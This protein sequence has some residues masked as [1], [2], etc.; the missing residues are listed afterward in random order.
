MEHVT[1]ARQSRLQARLSAVTS[2]PTAASSPS[3]SALALCNATS[4]PI[5]RTTKDAGDGSSDDRQNKNLGEDK[6]T[7]STPR[8]TP[9][10]STAGATTSPDMSLQP[11]REALTIKG[12]DGRLRRKGNPAPV[13]ASTTQR[14]FLVLGL[15]LRIPHRQSRILRM[16]FFSL[17]AVWALWSLLLLLS[18]RQQALAI[19]TPGHN[20]A[21]HSHGHD[22]HGH[23]SHKFYTARP[24]KA[25][26]FASV[27]PSFAA[28][29]RVDTVAANGNY[30]EGAADLGFPSNAT[31]LPPLCAVTVA[32]H[33]GSSN[34]RLALFLPTATNWN[35][36]LMT[37]GS[38]SFAGGINW[39]NMGEA[40]HYGFAT[41]ATDGGHNSSQSDLD[42]APTTPA[43]LA[44]W[45]Y[46]AL[47]GTVAL[48]KTLVETYYSDARIAYSYYSGCSTGGR[49][50]LKEIQ[51]SPDSFDGA[52]VGA[53]AWDTSRLMPWLTRIGAANLPDDGAN[54]IDLPDFA[55]LAAAALK[56]CDHLDGHNDSII[57][58][59]EACVLDWAP[60]TCGNAAVPPGEP[61]LTP[62]QV[63]TARYLYADAFTAS[64]DFIH[65][66]YS[67]GSEDQWNVYLAFGDASDFDTRYERFW[68]YN[69]TTWN[70]TLYSDQVFYDSLRLNLGNASADDYDISAYRDRGGKVLMY[71]GLADGVITPRMTTYYYNQTMKAMNLTLATAL[72]KR[73]ET[74]ETS[75]RH[76]HHKDTNPPI[77]DFFR[78]IQVPGMQHC[79]A[80]PEEVAAPWMFASP[81]QATLLSQDYG[82]GPGWGVPNQPASAAHDAVLALMAWV[83]N[84]VAPTSIVASVWNPDGTVNRTRPLCVYPQEAVYGGKGSLNVAANWSCK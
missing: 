29:E 64:D 35:G 75:D 82:F 28:I 54:H 77:Q 36:R 70:W 50:G 71:Q 6:H 51:I 3:H 41:L 72:D 78:Y 27:L 80:S 5:S 57:S 58:R 22:S 55:V 13:A 26:T 25:A 2:T 30:G 34:Y 65:S 60:I 1:L 38:Y 32:V 24:C 20:D 15:P 16:A 4:T 21:H 67:L 49:Q 7:G 43:K 23:D 33:N 84:A 17:A 10:P 83:E 76:P 56:Q 46:R 52:L 62:A 44:D 37:I 14:A 47:H 48:G 53:P 8:T 31:L 79:F 40:P 68:L 9:L 66:G 18:G 45:G 73:D 59:P 63:K 69:D 74:S 42:W 11:R 61:C 12:D 19:P 39:P 81:G